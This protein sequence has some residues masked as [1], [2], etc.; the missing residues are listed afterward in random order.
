M[1]SKNQFGGPFGSSTN[2]VEE[3]K[4]VLK[5]RKD[6]GKIPQTD[7]AEDKTSQGLDPLKKQIEALQQKLIHADEELKKEKHEKLRVLADFDNARKRLVREQEESMRYGNE[8]LIKEFLPIL[9]S[10]EMTV[11]H[12]KE[13]DVSETN[14]MLEGLDLILKQVQ[15][16]LAK[17]G[18]SMIEGY[19]KPFDPHTQEA[20][21]KVEHPEVS[22]G[23]V[24]LVH[25]KGYLLF[26]RV[27][28]PAMVSVAET[29]H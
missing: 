10:L 4:E 12:S 5:G 27:I 17:F 1:T 18:V 7:T 29:L 21:G 3:L 22:P 19:G 9:D 16:L 8:K 13:R 2:K 15:G 11:I 26:D 25:R 23:H 14:P 20:I 24:A 28:R 6:P